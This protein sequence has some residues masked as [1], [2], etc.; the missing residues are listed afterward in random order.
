MS[1]NELKFSGYV[2]RVT[3]Y[4]E[5]DTI[6]TVLSEESK[7]ISFKARGILKN[8]NKNFA[9][10]QLYSLSEFIL[11][12]PKNSKYY[13][14][15]T[16][17]LIKSS[18]IVYSSLDAGIVLALTAESILRIEEYEEQNSYSLFKKMINYLENNANPLIL[19]LSI[20]KQN[21]YLL[22]LLLE[23]NSCVECGNKKNIIAINYIKG[24]F[25]C[26]RCIGNSFNKKVSNL[27]LLG[28][29]KIINSSLDELLESNL[30]NEIAKTFI[31]EF[32]DFLES[33][34]G[35]KFK[36]FSLV[37]TLL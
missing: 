10:C 28:F 19:V 18:L 37:K 29:R 11:T 35:M 24:G 22:G 4:K 14:L 26:S 15:K 23:A 36:S 12:K 25:I 9:A 1:D 5:S 13:V 21:M 7:F 32:T 30:K 3:Q 34:S 20:L 6:L 17:E 27:Y 33:N 2:L 16:A 8:T 31:I